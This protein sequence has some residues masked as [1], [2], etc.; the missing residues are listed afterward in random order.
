MAGLHASFQVEG[1]TLP[2]QFLPTCEERPESALWRIVVDNVMPKQ[3]PLRSATEVHL[4]VRPEAEA[5]CRAAAPPGVHVH[6]VPS[7][8]EGQACTVLTLRHIINCDTPLF[9]CNAD[10]FLGWDADA[11]YRAAFHPSYDG[12]CVNISKKVAI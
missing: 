8:S 3:E 2:K 7:L 4:V 6:V 5:A 11:I 12:A 10:Q 9:I 1:F